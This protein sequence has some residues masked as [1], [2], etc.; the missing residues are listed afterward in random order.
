MC[1]KQVN[2]VL[3]TEGNANSLVKRLLLTVNL[4]INSIWSFLLK[5][6]I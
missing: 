6:H 2:Y 3:I 4:I 5:E 1:L